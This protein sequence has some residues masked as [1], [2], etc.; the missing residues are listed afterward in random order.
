M[1]LYQLKTFVKV[2]DEGNLTRAAEQLFTSQ[3]AVSAHIKA[4]EEE[5]GVTLFARTSKGMSLSPKGEILYQQAVATLDAAADLKTQALDLQQEVV[6]ELRIGV[7]T[8]FNFMRIGNLHRRL[9]DTHRRISPHFVQSMTAQI[10][11]NLRNGTLDGGFFFGPC[12]Y[13]DLSTITLA[14]VPM[15]IVGPAAWE[16][17]IQSADIAALAQMPWVYT[18]DSC[19][20][21]ALTNELFEDLPVEPN[22]VAW[23]DSEDAVR[24]LIRAGAGLSMLR[25]DDA[26]RLVEQGAAT[27]WTLATPKIELGFAVAQQRVAEPAIRALTE[28][29]QRLWSLESDVIS[30]DKLDKP[31]SK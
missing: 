2:A 19:P 24:E 28:E 11:P 8:D 4:L 31:Q 14:T 21:Y 30:P 25:A 7:H 23:V 27:A 17:R 26:Q 22:K 6:G 9:T 29:I 16:N 18:S 15:T 3:P 5:L 10:L 20:F 12:S 13:A 1:E